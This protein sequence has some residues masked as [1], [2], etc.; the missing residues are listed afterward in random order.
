M[1]LREGSAKLSGARSSPQVSNARL[2]VACQAAGKVLGDRIGAR[3]VHVPATSRLAVG[4]R[5][6]SLIGSLEQLDATRASFLHGAGAE[7]RSCLPTGR[8]DA[9]SR[10]SR[11]RRRHLDVGCF[12]IRRSRS[13]VVLRVEPA[14]ARRP[15]TRRVT[16]TRSVG[17]GDPLS[18]WSSF[19]REVPRHEPRRLHGAVWAGS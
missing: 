11:R 8:D 5:W 10:G 13:G 17:T 1:R 15:R 2:V 16:A 19:L 3:P 9:S 7:S 4:W 12:T 18:R 14:T 6:N